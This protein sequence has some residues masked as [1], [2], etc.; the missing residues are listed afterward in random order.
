[1]APRNA[2]NL[3]MARRM[4]KVRAAK[5]QPTKQQPPPQRQPPAAA[6]GPDVEVEDP[7]EAAPAA[8][9]PPPEAG[10]QAPPAPN[11]AG[12]PAAATAPQEDGDAQQQRPP[13][14]PTGRSKAA[15]AEFR[16]FFGLDRPEQSCLP[17]A[18]VPSANTAA[19]AYPPRYA[20][21]RRCNAVLEGGMVCGGPLKRRRDTKCNRC[22]NRLKK[23]RRKE[24]GVHKKK[25]K[26]KKSAAA[27][28]AAAAL[29]AHLAHVFPAGPA[30]GAAP[31]VVADGLFA[32]GGTGQAPAGWEEISILGAFRLPERDLGA[33]L[34]ARD[35]VRR[36]PAARAD[37]AGLVPPDLSGEFSL[38]DLVAKAT[39]NRAYV[40]NL[41]QCL[42]PRTR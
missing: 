1:M 35:A 8:A 6:P 14:P 3:A 39:A 16:D 20:G 27:A 25:K 4:A 36:D 32:A 22:H 17:A 21:E 19:Q 28:P 23:Q 15:E 33:F 26:K 11:P 12:P 34:R 40:T 24:R 29:P 42:A 7:G 41:L 13:P 38:G 10:G 30:A 2:K 37:F 18:P 5:Q 31:P 9:A